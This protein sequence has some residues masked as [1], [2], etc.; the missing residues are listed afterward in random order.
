M[1]PIL[2]AL[3]K[4]AGILI[5][6]LTGFAYMT[7]VER[8]FIGRLQARLGPNRAGPF[9][10]LQ[11]V[12][13]GL[14]LIFKESITPANVDVLV[15]FL[16]PIVAVVPALVLFAVIPFGS[17]PAFQL[18]SNIN[19]GAL[20]VMAVL[21]VGIY[22][23][24]LAGWSS[25]NKYAL[26]GGLR[27]S[28]QVI[29]YELGLGLAVVSVILMASSASLNDIVQYQQ[30]G[31]ILGW[32][33]F[34]QPVAAAL[35][36]V[37]AMAELARAPFDLVE[38]EQELTAGFMT[39]YG[40]MKFALFYM[41]EYVKMIGMSALFATF[42]LGG[43]SGPFVNEAPVLS[44]AYFAIKVLACLLV[45]VWVRATLPRFRYDKL[46]SFGWKVLLPVGLV[47]VVVTALLIVAGVPGYK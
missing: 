35:F 41:S 12:A 46:M 25:N 32:L 1:N 45:M 36:A 9:G 17:D 34:R 47:N 5:V 19:V 26:L 28:A 44:L 42:F 23:M 10:L 37:T 13:D 22:G 29:S 14:K 38:A 3:L 16:A 7:W 21:G 24:I 40:G 2:E 18:A 43:W 27:A 15:Y 31:N 20:Y 39:E 4:S 30:P 33:I 11:P 6:T 8:K